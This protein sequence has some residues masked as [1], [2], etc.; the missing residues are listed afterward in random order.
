[1]MMRARRLAVVAAL[2][3]GAALWAGL[4]GAAPAS[5]TGSVYTVVADGQPT[6]GESWAFERFFP[7][8]IKVH[9]GDIITIAW[10][11]TD[12]PHTASFVN[13]ADPTAWRQQ[14]QA[15]GATYAVAV[16]DTAVGGDDP[17]ET[18]LN[19]T[20]L[21]PS[22]FGCGT[23]A[24]PCAFDGTSVVSSGLLFSNPSAQPTF[25]VRV[26]APVGHYSLLCLIHGGMEIS[27]DVVSADRSIP[28]PAQVAAQ[29]AREAARANGIDAPKA[30]AQAQQVQTATIAGG[31]TR[32]SI[33]AGGFYKQVSANEYPDAG[34]T[35][36]VGDQLQVNGLEEIHTATFPL[37]AAST[38]P[39]TLSQCEVPGP[40]TPATSP[41]DC[42]SPSQFQVALNNQAVAPTPSNE[43]V[44]PAAFVNG[45]LIA[46]GQSSTFVAVAPGTY[47][48]VCLVHGPEMSTAVTVKS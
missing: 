18:V 16:P 31:H 33:S 40:D 20:V 29:A 24:A 5:A 23:A 26:T 48:M 46:T 41:A 17:D 38:V 32:W 45:G 36:R 9:Q 39:F 4:L 37:S 27:V 12:F 43:L 15:P 19:P 10:N 7:H 42:A 47:T 21:F 6:P 34:L 3:A 8:A 30:D 22:P 13:T 44:D 35:L 11:G 28:S 14:Q 2:L 25:S 1:M